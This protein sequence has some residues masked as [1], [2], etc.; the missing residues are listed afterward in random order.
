MINLEKEIR[1]QPHVLA[2]I[3]EVNKKALSELAS[4][5]KAKN[6]HKIYFAARG[7]SDHAATYAQYL[8]ALVCGIPCGLATPSVIS[9]YGAAVDYSDSLVIG[10]SQS[11]AA[12]DV[13]AV[14]SDA[15]KS[16]AITAGITN[17][18]D[19]HLAK[20]V[21]FLFDCHAGAETSIAATKTFTA[22]MMILALLAAEISGNIELKKA[23]SEVPEAMSELLSYMPETLSVLTAKYKD[24]QDATTLGRGFAYP[25]ALEGALKILETNCIK[26]RGYAI[27]DF[28]HGPIA[29]LHSGDPVF[30][31]SLDGPVADDTDAM[32]A[33]LKNIGTD[34]I[35]VSDSD[36]YC[37]DDTITTLKIPQISASGI[38]GDALNV[39]TAATVFQLF[40]CKLAENR[41]I[42]P[43]E[44]KTLKKV[45]VTV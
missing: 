32:I 34:I 31:I 15:K 45:T 42:D 29:Q 9:K 27:S 16:G 41:G 19:S 30:V 3:A 26:V 35:V 36:K 11:G 2:L 1:E 22:Q 7:T 17:I 12:E 8:F 44:S 6:I 40:A 24:M 23:L 43:D 25:I 5:M 33:R 38:P 10:I 39:F 18:T 21:D 37:D 28:H 14:I 13:I 20:S 4:E